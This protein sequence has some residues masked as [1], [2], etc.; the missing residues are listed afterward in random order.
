MVDD[1]DD[2][3]VVGE[4]PKRTETLG[5]MTTVET[6]PPRTESL[7]EMT[8]VDAPPRSVSDDE[9]TAFKV[10]SK[11]AQAPVPAVKPLPKLIA[12]PLPR[13][14]PPMTVTTDGM[15]R[16]RKVHPLVFVGASVFVLALVLLLIGLLRDKPPP[17]AAEGEKDPNAAKQLFDFIK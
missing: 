15:R 2:A 5:E 7:G 14:V 9:V 16:V 6:G 3:T 11:I 8:S 10:P 12:P 13:N 1:D 17:E 4:G